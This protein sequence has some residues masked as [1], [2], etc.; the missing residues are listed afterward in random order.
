MVCCSR[1]VGRNLWPARIESPRAVIACSKWPRFASNNPRVRAES[2]RRDG[3]GD[4]NN[5]LAV[6]LRCTMVAQQGGI[7]NRVPTPRHNAA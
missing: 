1:L 2:P 6:G 7:D 4:Q 5:S 3:L